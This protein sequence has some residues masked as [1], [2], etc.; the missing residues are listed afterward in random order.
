MSKG[1][2]ADHTSLIDQAGVIESLQLSPVTET[3]W[4]EVIQKMDSVY[5]DLVR[6]QVELEEKNAALEEAQQFIDSVLSAMTDVLIVCDT[7]GIIQQVN[8]ALEKLT[9]KSA[10]DFLHR[11]LTEVFSRE[12]SAVVEQ[13]AHKLCHESLVDCEVSVLC[14]DGSRA[15]LAMNGSSRYDRE[16]GLLGMVLIG[17]PIGELRRAYDDLNHTLQELK[18]AQQ[19][20]VHAEKMASLGRLVA[21]VAHELN[22]PISFVFGN[23]HALKR[24]TARICE[25][26]VEVE[27]HVDSPSLQQR[28]HDLKIDRILDDMGPL[29]DGTLEGAERVSD[30]VQDLRRYSG[31]QKQACSRFDLTQLIKKAVQWVLQASRLKPQVNYQLPEQFE[32]EGP[33]G[34]IHQ[35]LVNLVQNALDAMAEQRLSELSLSCEGVE[36]RVRIQVRDQGPGIAVDD[37]AKIFE[38]FFTRKPVGQGTG[39]GL[40]IS[41]GLA[42]DLGGDL[43]ADNHPEGGAVFTLTLPMN[44]KA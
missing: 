28:R 17:R 27:R 1:V 16:R 44:A 37:L 30:I 15:P 25:Y 33:K 7:Q 18:Q 2:E 41:Y 34:Q 32:I 23:M 10:K 20:L 42:R 39:L 19:Q 12:A 29:V 36:Q 26:L 38:P 5:A 35:V 24:Y 14:A 9:G 13:L 8:A 31:V 40:Y 3:V 43:Q 6:S 4:I 21:G 22:N 11:P